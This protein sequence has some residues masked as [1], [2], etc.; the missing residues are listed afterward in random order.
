MKH[1]LSLAPAAALFAGA[2]VFAQ[3][4]TFST[5]IAVTASPDGAVTVT[6]N[7]TTTAISLKTDHHG[8]AVHDSG[9]ADADAIMK[10]VE[11]AIRQ[12]MSKVGDVS[13]TTAKALEQ[14][15][16]QVAAALA[17]A[18][19]ATR[20]LA[21]SGASGSAAAEPALIF[22]GSME[23]D[24]RAA[25][26]EDLKV[27]DKLLRDE[28]NRANGDSPRQALGIHVFLW[29]Q[30][31]A[32]PMYLEGYGALFR[33]NADL[34]LASSGKKVEAKEEPTT[35]SV[36]ENAKREVSGQSSEDSAHVWLHSYQTRPGAPKPARKFSAA[37]LDELVDAVVNVLGEA[38][39]I[40]HLRADEHVTVT[41]SGADDAGSPARLTFKAKKE[42]ID[43][44]GSGQI[45]LEEFKSKVAQSAR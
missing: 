11:E 35:S 17:G 31:A 7:R 45:K 27:M 4:D 15:R 36:W 44:F 30:G 3:S 42:D 22:T 25:W 43:R 12:S 20:A 23:A 18:K 1:L 21:Y 2:T 41:I 38:K 24:V 13:A 32:Q 9:S 16:K 40:R 14:A 39:N 8:L 6:S 28:I 26:L 10:Q 19:S 37:K 5:S 29:D 34:A 33:Y